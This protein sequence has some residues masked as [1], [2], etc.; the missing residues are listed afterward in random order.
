MLYGGLRILHTLMILVS[1]LPERK[2]EL[3]EEALIESIKLN[4]I[5]ITNIKKL[6][7]GDNDV[8]F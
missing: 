8:I 1:I 2:L 5:I 3:T 7:A 6:K 4:D